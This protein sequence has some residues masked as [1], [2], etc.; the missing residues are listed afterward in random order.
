LH[1]EKFLRCVPVCYADSAVRALYA[2]AI[3]AEIKARDAKVAR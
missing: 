3:K 1:F 2:F